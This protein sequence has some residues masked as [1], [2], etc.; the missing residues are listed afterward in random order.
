M[1]HAYV[2]VITAAGTSE[3][4]RN[5][6][7]DLQGVVAAHIVAGDYD[8]IVEMDQASIT[9]L[10]RIVSTEIGEIEGV[11]TTRTYIAID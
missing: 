6:V 7:S 10:L 1:V 3:A 4:V 9:D 11:G 2:L 8:L 5:A